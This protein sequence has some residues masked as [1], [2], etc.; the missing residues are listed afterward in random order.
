LLATSLT[1][2]LEHGI[3]PVTGNYCATIAQVLHSAMPRSRGVSDG[4]SIAQRGSAR[5]RFDA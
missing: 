2:P 1:Q 5:R 4:R 3:G